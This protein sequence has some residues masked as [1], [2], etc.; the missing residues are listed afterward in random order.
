MTLPLRIQR[1]RTKGFKLPPNTVSVARPGAFGNHYQ[2]CCDDDD[3]WTVS[4]R[5]C[6]YTP[7]ENTKIAAGALAV[8]LFRKDVTT[9]GPHNHRAVDPVPTH[10]D[11]IKALRGKN[12]ACFCNLCPKHVAGKPMGIDCTACQPCHVDPLLEIANAGATVFFSD[13]DPEFAC[14]ATETMA[15]ANKLYDD[16]D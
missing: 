4:W 1:K 8:E 11:I 14:F 3:Q 2:V 9:E 16:D 5:R 12:L 15:E 10:S 7:P 13:V 6:H